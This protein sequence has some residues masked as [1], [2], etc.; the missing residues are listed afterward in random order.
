MGKQ[1]VCV[2][3]SHT[4][5]HHDTVRLAPTLIVFCVGGII[6]ELA[7]LALQENL[8][9]GAGLNCMLL[10]QE[11]RIG[12]CPRFHNEVWCLLAYLIR[13]FN[14]KPLCNLIFS[15]TNAGLYTNAHSCQIDFR[16]KTYFLTQNQKHT[17]CGDFHP[18]HAELGWDHSD[19]SN[20]A[21]LGTM[22]HCAT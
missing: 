11:V 9:S 7:V 16:L 21:D 5:S 12:T 3:L 20:V 14:I 6:C 15:H 22:K 1:T 8:L 2:S 10:C 19:I 4:L 13:V 17:Q 18:R